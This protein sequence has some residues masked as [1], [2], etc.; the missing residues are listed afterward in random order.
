MPRRQKKTPA[1]EPDNEALALLNLQKQVHQITEARA[2]LAN[3]MTLVRETPV[4]NFTSA[5]DRR[6][7]STAQS[8]LDSLSIR[9]EAHANTVEETVKQKQLTFLLHQRQM[10]IQAYHI[11]SAASSLTGCLGEREWGRDVAPSW[12]VSEDVI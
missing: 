2:T 10:T 8:C 9:L 4:H 12:V 1:P 7:L 5:Q 6:T 11:D 3:V